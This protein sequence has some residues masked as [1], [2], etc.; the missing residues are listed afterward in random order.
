MRMVRDL[1]SN[2]IHSGPI[3]VIVGA[4]PEYKRDDV[5]QQANQHH[6]NQHKVDDLP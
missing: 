6:A 2:I 4:S 3:R 1:Y 5:P